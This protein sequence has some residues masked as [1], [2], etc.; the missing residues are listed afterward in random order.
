MNE[1]ETKILNVDADKVARKMK[2]LGAKQILAT[3]L[4][5][6]WFRPKGQVSGQEK[7][8]LRVRSYSDGKVEVTWKGIS[9]KLG[10]AR[11]HKEINFSVDSK[12]QILDLFDE[13]GLEKYAHQEKDRTSWKLKNW[14]FDL[15]KYPKVP[16]YLEIEGSSERSIN[17]AIKV[18]GLG[19][20]EALAE[21]E[22]VVIESVYKLNWLDM[23]FADERS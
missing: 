16:V 15:D 14:R 17:E 5:V 8:F 7:W 20:Y 12:N 22:R 3:R 21:G 10:K 19:K 13:L 9:S 11:K 6:D 23:R 2:S 4:T 18:L 1:I